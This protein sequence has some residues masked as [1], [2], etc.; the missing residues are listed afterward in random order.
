MKVGAVNR[1]RGP[2]EIGIQSLIEK[3]SHYQ[4]FYFWGREKERFIP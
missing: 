4:S 2:K 1:H 3:F